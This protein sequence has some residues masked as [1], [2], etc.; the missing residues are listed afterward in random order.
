M[1]SFKYNVS[2]EEQYP[3]IVSNQIG[4]FLYGRKEYVKNNLFLKSYGPMASFHK[5]I[6]LLK[7][8]FAANLHCFQWKMQP[9]EI[10]QQNALS[11]LH[12]PLKTMQIRCKFK[13]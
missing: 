9:N 10:S 6:K 7:F 2:N 13:L 5:V 8:K 12:L 3:I 11:R 4:K 1:S